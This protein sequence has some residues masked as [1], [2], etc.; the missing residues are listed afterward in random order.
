MKICACCR[1]ALIVSTPASRAACKAPQSAI[2][3]ACASSVRTLA[4]SEDVSP[5]LRPNSSEAPM[6]LAMVLAAK[7]PFEGRSGRATV[8]STSASA[9]LTVSCSDKKA[10]RRLR[11]MSRHTS[12]NPAPISMPLRTRIIPVVMAHPGAPPPRPADARRRRAE[13]LSVGRAL[14]ALPRLLHLHAPRFDEAVDIFNHGRLQNAERVIRRRCRPQ[15]RLCQGRRDDLAPIE[16]GFHSLA[17][18]EGNLGGNLQLDVVGLP[19][20]FDLAADVV[21]IET[22]F[23][24][25]IEHGLNQNAAIELQVGRTACIAPGPG[26]FCL[27]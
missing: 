8:I 11:R 27:G 1:R 19:F 14:F 21:G 6:A 4:G 9:T 16:A 18:L 13:A 25:G 10:C 12:A 17:L 7:T 23:N 24:L 5:S 3:A 22:H 2:T 26:Q 15:D 20:T